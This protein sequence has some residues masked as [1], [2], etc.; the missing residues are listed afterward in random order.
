MRGVNFRKG[1]RHQDEVTE[2]E[3][4]EYPRQEH[5][6]TLPCKGD[7]S[8]NST[9]TEDKRSEDEYRLKSVDVQTQ[10]R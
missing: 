3:E 1:E 4:N 8:L 7:G 2:R 5:R 10:Q 6:V 9:K